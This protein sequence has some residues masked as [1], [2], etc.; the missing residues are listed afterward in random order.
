MALGAVYHQ[1]WAG[2]VW[3]TRAALPEEELALAGLGIKVPGEEVYNR[4]VLERLGVKRAVI[5]LLRDR[6][7]NTV[8]EVQIVVR[9]LRR[10]GGERVILVTSKAH[11]RRVRA[12]WSG[13]VGN[14][15][16]AVVRYA[17]QDP[18]DPNRWWRRTRDAL[19]VSREIFGLMNVWAGFPVKQESH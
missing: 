16:Q 2:E 19:A 3:L 10:V 14:D 17:R 11:T 8:E 5:H 15:P 18:Y 6:V 1:G 12:T 7:Q 13:L 9:E 4:Q